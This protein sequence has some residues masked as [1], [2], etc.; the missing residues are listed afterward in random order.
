[1]GVRLGRYCYETEELNLSEN[2]KS[3]QNLITNLENLLGSY[4][5]LW[6]ESDGFCVCSK[7]F[8]EES[9]PEKCP[10]ETDPDIKSVELKNGWFISFTDEE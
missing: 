10:L 3:F 8:E 2:R 6:D 5:A 4:V 1:M 9:C 7:W